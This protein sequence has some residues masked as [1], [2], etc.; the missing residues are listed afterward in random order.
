[1]INKK[2]IFEKLNSEI[3]N[4]IGVYALMGNLQAE[5]ALNPKNLQNSYEKKLG[6]NDETYTKAVDEGK[7]DFVNDRA[8]YGLAQWT[9]WSRKS[10]LLNYAKKSG[11][12][13]GDLEMQI[14]F[15]LKELK[16][17]PKVWKCLTKEKDLKKV[18]DIILTDYERPSD[19]SEKNKIYRAGL[20]EKIKKEFETSK[21]S[22]SVIADEVIK[23]LWGNGDERK[24]RL[25]EA[26]YNYRTI[27]NA[28]NKKLKGD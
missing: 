19:Q 25:E 15:L 5:S 6:F 20:G 10:S 17:Y 22:T 18:S 9:F 23:G 24:K 1:M 21:K 27:Q 13:I 26:G 28:V 11:K 7:H 3:K 2:F 8:G 14:N 16:G 4:H 12:S